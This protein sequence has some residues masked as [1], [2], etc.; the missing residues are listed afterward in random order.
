VH[1]A[2]P[3]A[4]MPTAAEVCTAPAAMPTAAA[5]PSASTLCISSAR[6]SARQSDN[7]KDFDF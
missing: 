2:T 4:A 1:A 3:G 6:Q 5:V 7:G